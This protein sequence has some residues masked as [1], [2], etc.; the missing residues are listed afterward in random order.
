VFQA[1]TARVYKRDKTGRVRTGTFKGTPAHF[2]MVLEELPKWKGLVEI[3]KEIHE[4][5]E[6]G[7]GI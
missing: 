2:G 6:A 3:L 5:R 4:K 1:A 7:E